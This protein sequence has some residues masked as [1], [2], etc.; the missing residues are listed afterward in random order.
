MTG[1]RITR[2]RVLATLGV[3][4]VLVLAAVAVVAPRV[5][6]RHNTVTVQFEDAVGLYVGNAVSVLGMPVG[7]VTNVEAKDGYVEVTME[8]DPKVAIPADV[9]AVTVSVSLLTDRHIELTPPYRDGPRLNNG[10]VIGL[11]RTRTPVEF[12]RTLA[13]MDKLGTALR[14]NGEGGG[15]LGDL[16]SIGYQV[17]STSGPD[18][19]ATLDKLSQALRVGPDGG[20]RT[21]QNIQK[22]VKSMAELT[23]S[24]A[25]N[26]T[27]I[28]EFGSYVRQ[29]SDLLADE[30]L[31]T[32]NAG[33]KANQLL[34]Q[35]TGL[36]ERHRDELRGL[37]TDV[38]GITKTLADNQRNLAEVLDVGPL[39]VDNIYRMIDPVGGSIRV[40]L[41][42]DKL[43]FNSQMGKEV[44]NLM[45]LKQLG[46]ATGT[47]ADYGP[48]FGLTSMLD[49]M[50]NGIE[51]GG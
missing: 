32:G 51:G 47:L 18:I 20:K 27:A 10:D 38:D 29:L 40:H 34:E 42:I 35:A 48:D 37:F 36:L 28:R 26:D 25:D 45:G 50:A 8:L 31:G 30:Q 41:M 22:I 15:P 13:M 19:K 6:W 3:I 46:C 4:A 2:F 9:S 43:L 11:G 5:T 12:D 14:G 16:V 49:L 7:E 39:A 33:A 44:C 23:E 1:S 24:A 21:Q 17:T